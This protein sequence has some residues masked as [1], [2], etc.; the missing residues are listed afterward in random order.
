MIPKLIHQIWIGPHPL[1]KE[2]EAWKRMN[3]TWKHRLWREADLAPL[4]GR[5]RLQPV[6]DAFEGNVHECAGRADVALFA[7]L[8]EQGGVYLDADSVP[9]KPLDERFAGPDFWV[10]YENEKAR[11][12]MVA[13]GAVGSIAGYPLLEKGLRELRRMQRI[14]LPA[15]VQT[16]PAF[17]TKLLRET[18]APAVIFPSYYFYPAH[19]QGDKDLVHPE[20]F[21]RHLWFSTKKGGE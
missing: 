12:R 17:L 2:I 14:D 10:C 18:G 1:P 16:G 9:L 4:I 6:W 11:G 3:P 21:A 8:N 5:N 19:H 20:S 7:I 13:N 15:W